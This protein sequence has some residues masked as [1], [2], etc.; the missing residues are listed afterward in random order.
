MD[1]PS[2][3]PCV[4]Y[5]RSRL[6]DPY[7]DAQAT[8]AQCAT[9]CLLT[10]GGFALVAS[11]GDPEL[12][13][14]G[15]GWSD[16]RAAWYLAIEKANEVSRHSGSC[17]LL[18]LRADGIGS[19]DPFLPDP[20]GLPLDDN[21]AIRVCGFSLSEEV[22]LPLHDARQLLQRHVAWLAARDA[23]QGDIEVG[24]GQNELKFVH[25]PRA[26]STRVYYCNPT[27]EPL[28][29]RWK[30]STRMLGNQSAY[31]RSSDEWLELSVPAGRGI[32]LRT[33][34]QGDGRISHLHWR[35]KIGQ[36]RE[37][38][39]GAI[40]LGSDRYKAGSRCLTWVHYDPQ[41]LRE[42][43]FI[44]MNAPAL[45]TR[46]LRLRNWG[47]GDHVAYA[48][49]CNTP[50]VMKWLGGVQTRRQLREDVEYF[51][52]TGLEGPTYWVVE[53][54]HDGELLGFCGALV[55]EEPDSPV[56]GE[57]EIGWRIREDAWGQGYALE[58]AQEALRFLFE[59]HKVEKVVARVAA[60]NHASRRLAEQLAM[61]ENSTRRHIHPGEVEAFVVY[62]VDLNTWVQS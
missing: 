21:V 51:A 43:D 14:P 61:A 15:Y 55:V 30:E 26:R 41:P 52:G 4:M 3:N 25:D 58:A 2:E 57:W 48:Q 7:H 46:R 18:I 24:P 47:P 33:F 56:N 12:A 50:A 19:G 32:Y 22:S 8:A 1:Q 36:S 62:E 20:N 29:V 60:G 53:R 6:G 16:D 40:L 39:V 37:T 28:S 54:Q 38:R 45:T 49:H 42:T 11:Y 35:F 13:K 23:A 9:Q 27:P 34:V 5:F 10:A 31:L 44:W 59:D 17:T